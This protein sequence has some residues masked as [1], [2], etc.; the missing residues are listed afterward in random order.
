MQDPFQGRGVRMFAQFGGTLPEYLALSAASGRNWQRVEDVGGSLRWHRGK[1][2]ER[3]PH[4]EASSRNLAPLGEVSGPEPLDDGKFLS[5][6]REAIPRHASGL[7][8]ADR[9]D[10]R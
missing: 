3:R 5:R 2:F 9:L 10:R 8:F 6:N 7:R 4:D 1:G